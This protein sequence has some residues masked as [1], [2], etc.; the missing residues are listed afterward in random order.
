MGQTLA[1]RRHAELAGWAPSLEAV[2]ADLS[3]RDRVDSNRAAD[4]LRV[5]DNAGGDTGYINAWSI[6]L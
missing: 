2:A 1:R 3:R 6:S 5:S 4:P